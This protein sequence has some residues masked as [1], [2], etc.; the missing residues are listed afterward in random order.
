MRNVFER[1]HSESEV[2][3]FTLRQDLGPNAVLRLGHI[4]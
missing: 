2:D 1:L 4:I 3:Q